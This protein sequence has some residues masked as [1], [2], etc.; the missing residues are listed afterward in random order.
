MRHYA[1]VLR[2]A[3]PRVDEAERVARRIEHLFAR[4]PTLSADAPYVSVGALVD[5]PADVELAVF[6]LEEIRRP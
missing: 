2:I 1:A 3:A 4:T 5:V 6:R